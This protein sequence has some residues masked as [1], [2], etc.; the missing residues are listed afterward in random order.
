M[1][2][3]LFAALAALFLSSFAASQVIQDPGGV[4]VQSW[5]VFTPPPGWILIVRTPAC[6]ELRQWSHRGPHG[7]Y[8]EH[9][10]WATHWNTNSNFDASVSPSRWG[11]GADAAASSFTMAM[12]SA[13]ERL[14][15]VVLK[16]EARSVVDLANPDCGGMCAAR[17][18][19]GVSLD[20][21]LNTVEREV[22][23]HAAGETSTNLLGTVS[24]FGVSIKIESSSA[25]IIHG[26]P[27][28]FA[29]TVFG[30]TEAL[31]LSTATATVLQYRLHGGLF[32]RVRR[33]STAPRVASRGFS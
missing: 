8:L 10:A 9:S 19:I 7:S 12:V 25:G 2:R 4:P 23:S 21:G 5:P 14:V 13:R 29:H 3:Y 31:V 22:K 24:V 20:G 11:F 16:G 6:P 33:H 15:V 26:E 32:C 28:S 27:D 1:T 17:A 30:Q 18:T